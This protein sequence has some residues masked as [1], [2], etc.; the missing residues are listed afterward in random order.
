MFFSN[1]KHTLYISFYIHYKHCIILVSNTTAFA[2]KFDT[3]PSLPSQRPITAAGK[4]D[5]VS[6][7]EE[8]ANAS[9]TTDRTSTQDGI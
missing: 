3:I 5:E 7:S 2:Q 4:D 6:S 9:T 1:Y 8:A